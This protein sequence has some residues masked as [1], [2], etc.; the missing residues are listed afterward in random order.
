MVLLPPVTSSPINSDWSCLLSTSNLLVSVPSSVIVPA[1]QTSAAFAI[2]TNPLLSL[3]D[4]VVSVS[5]S[6]GGSTQIVP[7]T[8]MP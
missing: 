7:L 4:I 2:A 3:L 8:L 5:A 1:G 6:Y